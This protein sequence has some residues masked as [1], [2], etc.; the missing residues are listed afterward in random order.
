MT[1]LEL[2][3]RRDGSAPYMEEL[4]IIVEEAST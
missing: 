2:G 4:E 1:L 3:A